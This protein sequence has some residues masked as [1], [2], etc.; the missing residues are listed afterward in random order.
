M[1]LLPTYLTF[2]A[3]SKT[4]TNGFSYDVGKKGKERNLKV[5][6]PEK[7]LKTPMIA[8]AIN[9]TLSCE[10]LSFLSLFFWGAK[11]LMTQPAQKKRKKR[12]W[13]HVVKCLK[14]SDRK[15]EF[16]SRKKFIRYLE[17]GGDNEWIKL[18]YTTTTICVCNFS[19]EVNISVLKPHLSVRPRGHWDRACIFHRL[20]DTVERPPERFN[21]KMGINLCMICRLYF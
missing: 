18:H 7:I 1:S 5:S 9:L 20:V 3:L 15:F 14:E 21:R 10:K 11:F 4:L 19:G 16:N 17:R 13:T 6:F 8:N 2:W 12:N